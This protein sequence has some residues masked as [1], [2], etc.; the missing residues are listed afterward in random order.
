MTGTSKAKNP[1]GHAIEFFEETHKYLTVLN[2]KEVPY[3]SGTAFSHPFFPEFDPTGEITARC[4]KKEGITVEA[5]KAKW[6][7]KGAESCRLGTRTHETIEDVFHG[8]PF[9]NKAENEIEQMRFNN[10]IAI[11]KKIKQRLDILGIEMIVFDFFVC[12]GGSF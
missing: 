4:A 11:G 10:A 7:A 2:G 1:K 8:Q 5:I 9:R 12:F 3:T 6:A